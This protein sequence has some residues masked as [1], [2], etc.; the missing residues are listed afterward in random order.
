LCTIDPYINTGVPVSFQAY[1]E[2]NLALYV[3]VDKNLKWD[4]TH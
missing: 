1:K 3:P 4:D 2:N